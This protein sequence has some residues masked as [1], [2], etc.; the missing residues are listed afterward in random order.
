[1]SRT[2]MLVWVVALSVTACGTRDSEAPAAEVPAEPTAVAA[3][4]EPEATPE[5]AAAPLGPRY[6]AYPFDEVMQGFTVR[7][8]YSAPEFR[9]VCEQQGGSFEDGDGRSRGTLTCRFARDNRTVY[10]ANASETCNW[11]F[12]ERH[13][14][15]ALTHEQVNAYANDIR[16]LSAA[17]TR[18]Y[19]REINLEGSDD[20]KAEFQRGETEC[21]RRGWLSAHFMS[22]I[23]QH[24]EASHAESVAV[25]IRP[26]AEDNTVL[27]SR[28]VHV[29]CR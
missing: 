25:A 9:Q 23:E 26:F 3:E 20:C 7:H 6:I 2:L 19:M 27:L 8:A 24:P 13:P 10:V 5:P 11:G 21:L 4:P 18:D 1:M 29:D 28:N 17:Q 16:A 14:T 12:L 22:L 15:S